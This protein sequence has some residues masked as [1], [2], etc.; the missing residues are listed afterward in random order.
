MRIDRGEV[1]SGLIVIAFG[2]WFAYGALDYRIGSLARMGPGFVPYS[3]GLISVGLGTL[4][5]LSAFGRVGR[6]PSIDWRGMVCV[7]GAVG[8]FAWLLPRTGMIP[9]TIVGVVVA[10]V[11]SPLTHPPAVPILAVGVAA[12][13]WVVFALIL[14]IQIPVFR[15]PF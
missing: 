1:I 5:V 6:V 13:A 3:L 11:G 8:L 15:S 2:A 4:I 14:G 7:L 10:S 9:A 12:G